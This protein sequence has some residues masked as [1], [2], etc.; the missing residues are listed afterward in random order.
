MSKRVLIADDDPSSLAILQIMLESDGDFEIVSA[1]DGEEAWK[2][3]EGGGV[4]DVCILDVMMPVLDGLALTKRMR[5]HPALRD[6][7]VILCT[8]LHDRS[9][10]DQAAA[11]SVVNYIVK[12]FAREHV[13]KQV[14]RICDEHQAVTKLEPLARTAQRLGLRE[15]QVA[16]FLA[17]VIGDTTK[18][19][20]ALS[21]EPTEPGGASSLIRI[22]AV[23]G[24]AVN[25]GAFGL[26]RSLAALEGLWDDGA[27]AA[28]TEALRDVERECE[29]LRSLLPISPVTA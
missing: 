18:L 16:H 22:N 2:L 8:S 12:P 19:L 4:F 15:N 29:R 10:V 23:K 7:P 11:L 13:I 25:L 5:A 26:Y 24:A 27:P 6:Q 17:N 9:T 3:L 14:Q 21:A 20:A 28:I 1:Q